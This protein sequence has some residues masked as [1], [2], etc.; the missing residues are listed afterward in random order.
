[1]LQNFWQLFQEHIRNYICMLL[2]LQ[3][4]VVDWGVLHVHVLGIVYM[5]SER[6]FHT[7]LRGTL[8]K[9]LMYGVCHLE[10]ELN[11]S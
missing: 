3:N 2:W 5:H 1:M 11:N 7:I 6:I 9:E 10:L 8:A 4:V